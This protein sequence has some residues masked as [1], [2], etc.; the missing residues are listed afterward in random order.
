MGII[1]GELAAKVF[2]R[3]KLS[4]AILHSGITLGINTSSYKG[5]RVST[6]G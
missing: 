4:H 2:L 6:D 1:L 3:H 5:L